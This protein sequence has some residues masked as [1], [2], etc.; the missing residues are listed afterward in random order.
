MAM[1]LQ[2]ASL[3]LQLKWK[4]NKSSKVFK[5]TFFTV[6]WHV[7]LLVAPPAFL[8]VSLWRSSLARSSLPAQTT[9]GRWR[10]ISSWHLQDFK[11][12]KNFWIVTHEKVSTKGVHD[13][14][15]RYPM[16]LSQQMVFVPQDS[17]PQAIQEKE[18]MMSES[19]KPQLKVQACSGK[20][21]LATCNPYQ[22]FIMVVAFKKR[23][24]PLGQLALPFLRRSRSS[25]LIPLS[26]V[27]ATW[28]FRDTSKYGIFLLECWL[29]QPPTDFCACAHAKSR[30][31]AI[32]FWVAEPCGMAG[33]DRPL[34]APR[35]STLC[36]SKFDHVLLTYT[37]HA[38]IEM[39]QALTEAPVEMIE[40][41][42]PT[43]GVTKLGSLQVMSRWTT[44]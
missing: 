19:W 26:A 6:I 27:A 16:S 8:K 29:S 20:C 24:A 4:T 32:D 43:G 13:R 2:L 15:D 44:G 31:R 11:T 21:C 10:R 7:H 40:L 22:V 9:S 38:F 17:S 30:T 14:S 5:T 41:R 1:G 18:D 23:P 39:F 12:E 33:A 37:N 28:T 3:T 36:S 34:N 35:T 25:R 42:P